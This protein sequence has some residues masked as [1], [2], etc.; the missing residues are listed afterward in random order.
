M[1][2]VLAV[3]LPVGAELR[4]VRANRWFHGECAQKILFCFE[5]HSKTCRTMC[6][7]QPKTTTQCQP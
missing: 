4:T 5:N 1:A 6:Q 2:E 3:E 7:D